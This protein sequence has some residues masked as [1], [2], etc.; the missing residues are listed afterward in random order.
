MGQSSGVDSK[1]KRCSMC[2][3]IK[4]LQ[5]FHLNKSTKDGRQYRCKPCNCAA[6]Q[7]SYHKHRERRRASDKQRNHQ[8]DRKTRARE[9]QRQHRLRFPDRVR[10]RLAVAKAVRCGDMVRLPCRVCGDPD[11]Q[12]HHW[13]GYAPEHW[14]D[15]QYLCADHHSEAEKQKVSA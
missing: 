8:E 5:D 10:A 7:K 13:R 3:D 6:V 12:A 14:F 9:S 1:M 11:T 4:P 2:K 15:V